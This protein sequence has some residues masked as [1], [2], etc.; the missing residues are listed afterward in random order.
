M[1]SHPLPSLLSI[2]AVLVAAL[3]V[4]IAFGVSTDSQ[5]AQAQTPTVDYDTDGDTLIEVRTAAQLAAIAE[6][7]S[8][9]GLEGQTNAT[10]DA[11]FPNPAA[12]LGCDDGEGNQVACTGYEL[13]ADIALSGNWAPIA[14]YTGTF[15]GNGNTI[16]GL[17]INA[18][19]TGFYGLFGSVTGPVRNVGVVGVNITIET[20]DAQNS[21]FDVG[22][23]AGDS[24]GDIS[25]SYATGQITVTRGDNAGGTNAGG[26]VGAN[27]S[28]GTIIAS[29]ATVSVTVTGGGTNVAGGLV[30]N[31]GGASDGAIRASYAT[32]DVSATATGS[33]NGADAGGLVGVS[34]EDIEAS[35][36]TGD[37]SATATGTGVANAGGLV[38][39]GSGII[40]ASYSTG[41][42]TA[43]AD[44]TD[45]TANAGG[46][47]GAGN[48]NVSDAAPSYWNT[49]TSG[50]AAATTQTGVGTSTITLQAPI[51]Y[52]ATTTD[53]F[54]GWNL[55]IDRSPAP[56]S[57]PDDPWDFGGDWQY[58]V[59]KYGDLDPDDQRPDVTLMLSDMSISEGGTATVKATL[60]MASNQ[61]TQVDLAITDG[62]TL[63]ATSVTVPARSL[64][65][66]T[67]T[68]TAADNDAMGDN[69]GVMVSG[70]V[71][72]GSSGAEQ[73]MAV[74][75]AITDDDLAVMVE[76]VRVRTRETLA[77][78]TWDAVD[79]AT[80]YTVEWT[81]R[82]SR[83]VANWSRTSS[84]DVDGTSA[85]VRRLIP[86]TDY[87]FRVSVSNM[88]DSTSMAVV[89]TTEGEDDGASPFATMTPTPTPTPAATPIPPTTQV[90]TSTA[91]TL[92]SSDGTVTLELP[93][94]S[95]SEPY[96][97]NF[98]TA[99]GCSYAGAKADVSF[100]CVKALIFD[101]EDMLETDVAF[102][103]AP[104]IAFHLSAEQVKAL[105]GEFLLTKLHEMGG[106]MI[107][108]R[109]S[110]DSGSWTALE[111]TTL[112]F[113]D[114]TGGA[115]LA[116]WPASVTSFTAVVS[117]SA[118][119]TVQE[120][121][122]HLLPRP[123]LIPPTGGPS[124]PGVAL[125][126][127]LLGAAGLVA[128]GWVLTGRR[129]GA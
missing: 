85:T 7:S 72:Q 10:W 28:N 76:N 27:T 83:G 89:A 61:P 1:K 125:L 87:G 105:G 79:G 113:D 64:E 65:S 129:S 68:I 40:T 71:P 62:A 57:S 49:E 84:M 124:I 50:I 56:T 103:A 29:Y 126:A 80:G 94:G 128:T 110:A 93:A 38:G 47:D 91:T 66:G 74:T 75:L 11:A 99:T 115:V 20:G 119:D 46:L 24:S 121:Y 55:N 116:G 52:G 69:D 86:G 78:V 19:T 67:V 53:I 4:A 8:G 104:T 102:D 21:A 9:A 92:M 96:Q 77:V 12:G 37:V 82:V 58:P 26:L 70:M 73:P 16:S 122:G 101:S 34:G 51:G 35:Y 107:I 23:L 43:T 45:G 117:Q 127:L 14:S 60:D 98:E 6:D 90:G 81:A 100:T 42:P 36:A 111:G 17:T 5:T 95:R 114:E 33:N 123:K 48:A 88:A 32:G 44:E 30:G 120:T 2:A 54:F 18:T 15:D 39:S 31:N 118:Y 41:A 63:S 109:A 13:M 22:A 106:L 108:G 3:V 25:N 112:T 97:V 59:L